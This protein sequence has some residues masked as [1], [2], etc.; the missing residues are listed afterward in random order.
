MAPGRR[1]VGVVGGGAR[2]AAGADPGNVA[3][4]TGIVGLAY[5]AGFLAV[6]LPGGLGAREYVFLDDAGLLAPRSGGR[7]GAA[8]A[9]GVD[10]RGGGAGGRRCIC[11][12]RRTS[13]RWR[14]RANRPLAARSS[15]PHALRGAAS[16]AYTV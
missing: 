10:G 14:L 4:F 3:Q 2:R 13:R 9:A 7:R 15:P 16:G 11:C 5:V 12:P 8:D 1:R 6:F